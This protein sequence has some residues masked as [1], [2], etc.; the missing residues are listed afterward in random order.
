[1]LRAVAAATGLVLL[2][3]LLFA[4]W[5]LQ[6]FFGDRPRRVVVHKVPSAPPDEEL[7]EMARR[8]LQQ[9]A[10]ED[11]D[12]RNQAQQALKQSDEERKVAARTGE[13]QRAE[14]ARQERPELLLSQL[15]KA[16]PDRIRVK[17]AFTNRDEKAVGWDREFAVF[18]DWSVQTLE[19]KDVL[20]TEVGTMGRPE[21]SDFKTRFI[22]LAPGETISKELV[23]TEKVQ[24]FACGHGTFA[25]PGGA[26]IHQANGYEHTIRYV[27]P[28]ATAGV[29][30]RATYRLPFMGR[31]CFKQWFG[32]GVE[33]VLLWEGK[34]DASE[35]IIRFTKA[36]K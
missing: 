26:K 29:R 9:A 22:K 18:V 23:L 10:Q 35:L 28:Q 33:D 20:P 19:G 1:M 16:A 24:Q 21:K 11:E 4:W 8:V 27:I 31:E 5:Q 32:Y 25:G 12:L 17:I 3:F 13:P 15:G 34:T 36:D 14:A 7:R 2:A 6:P 30:V